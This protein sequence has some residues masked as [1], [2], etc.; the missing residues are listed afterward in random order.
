MHPIITLFATNKKRSALVVV[1]FLL[2]T[3]SEALS[4]TAVL[5]L[6]ALTIGD[7]QTQSNAFIEQ[8]H[9]YLGRVNLELTLETLLFVIMLGVVL[10]NIIVLITE[11]Y[12]AYTAAGLQTKLRL[13][14][15]KAVMKSK[16]QYLTHQP[17]GRL[18]NAMTIEA[19][20]SARAYVF[21]MEFISLLITI[22][23]YTIVAAAISWQAM[24]LAS[25]C[26]VVVWVTLQK[27]MTMARE[28]G[29]RQIEL[30]RS[31][32]SDMTDALHAVKLLKVMSKESVVDGLLHAR[33]KGLGKVLKRE[34][35]SGAMLSSAQEPL[36]VLTTIICILAAVN[37]LN[38]TA[39]AA[40]TLT[41]MIFRVL[42]SLG[43]VQKRYQKA[44]VLES[45][46]RAIHSAITEADRAREILTGDQK[47]Q[48]EKGI[49]LRDVHFAYPRRGDTIKQASMFIEA[50]KLT[51]LIGPSGAGKTTIV[52]LIT[53]LHRADKGRITI[54]G[55]D[56]NQLDIKAWRQMIGYVP[57]ESI[58]LH[59]S[60][61][62]N[63][64]L[65]EKRFSEEDA[66][67]ALAQAQAL[68]FVQQL[69]DSI[70]T[71]L[72][73]RGL[74]LSGGQRQRIMIARAL[75]Q[76]PKLLLLDEATASLDRRSTQQICE[77]LASLK[78]H[79]TMLAITHQ[80]DLVAFAD[81]IYHLSSSTL[82]EQVTST[83]GSETPQP[84]TS[85]TSA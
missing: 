28:A 16:W 42:M 4:I 57:Q 11:K 49:E 14:L 63:L 10:K 84:N 6:I 77:V 73:E 48:L 39:A 24:A 9:H 36:F 50:G 8:L 58:V 2:A 5:P 79:V 54:D 72:G 41:L 1:M 78:G 69:P 7:S 68:P 47:P 27:L 19:D 3:A 61:L 12:I 35:L 80:P 55:V 26:I 22:A 32:I 53:G 44:L 30:Y 64:T 17:T 46:Y 67:A 51:A 52:D 37:Y 75:I 25:I 33:N 82:E 56:I 45:A 81:K 18:T 66:H 23:I 38:T 85:E 20:R 21:A 62:H 29:R 71:S 13:Q 40:L 15:L 43:K 70:H 34:A 76:K 60:I 59:N 31:L 74:T 83:Q 65:G